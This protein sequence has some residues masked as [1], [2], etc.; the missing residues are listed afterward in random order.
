ML[1]V[2]MVALVIL[3]IVVMVSTVQVN[4]TA[5]SVMISYYIGILCEMDKS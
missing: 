1:L 2:L 3:V 5:I 4:I